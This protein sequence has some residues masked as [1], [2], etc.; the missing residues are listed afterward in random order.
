MIIKRYLTD[1]NHLK[2]YF[3]MHSNSN[4]MKEL[5]LSLLLCILSIPFVNAQNSRIP[6]IDKSPMD[7]SYYPANYPILKI[8]DKAKEPV[9][10]RVT[11]SRPQ[12]NGR[13]VF[14]ELIEYG[15]I[16]RL[17]ANEATELE[18]FKD[19]RI[20]TTKVKKGRYTMYAIPLQDKWT[21]I[22][23]KDT[24]TWGAF[25]YDPQKDV[26]RVEVKAEKI[27]EQVESFTMFFEKAGTQINL[28]IYWDNYR[29]MVP[30]VF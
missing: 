29:A 20:G 25:K 9:M 14:G 28:N 10:A 5:V 24:D 3:C 21:I 2:G 11:Y 17:G 27:A 7:M 16:W 26:A 8:Q 15:S 13:T 4:Y 19:A 23:N 22:L 18:L 30:F 6:A 12:K 1:E